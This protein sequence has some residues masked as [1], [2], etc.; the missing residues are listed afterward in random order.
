[1]KKA[2]FALTAL[3]MTLSSAHASAVRSRTLATVAHVNHD[4]SGVKLDESG[5][6]TVYP[7]R[8]RNILYKRLSPANTQALVALA[9]SLDGVQVHIE[10]RTK[11][12]KRAIDPRVQPDLSVADA[13]V[14][15]EVRLVM[16]SLDCALAEVRYPANP[17]DL[18]S[19]RL[20]QNA[21]ITL[22]NEVV[23]SAE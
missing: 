12:C 5:L 14:D 20:L 2:L 7:A 4:V 22:G 9:R 23:H 6:L 18:L 11:L 8:T 1:M 3:A 10:E 16:S 21:L 13:R 17:Q 19:A 15:A